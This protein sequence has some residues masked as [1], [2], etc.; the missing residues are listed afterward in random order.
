MT[1]HVIRSQPAEPPGLKMAGAEWE[2]GSVLKRLGGTWAPAAGFG[3]ITST[4]LLPAP[5]INTYIISDIG[6]LLDKIG[7]QIRCMFLFL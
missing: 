3:F 5:V 2:F 7:L 4:Y 6:I 1:S